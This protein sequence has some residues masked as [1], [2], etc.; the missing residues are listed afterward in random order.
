MTTVV[1]LIA[2]SCALVGYVLAMGLA[3]AAG[4]P[5]PPLFPP[6]A[7]CVFCACTGAEHEAVWDGDEFLGTRCEAH[8]GH[9]FAI[10]APA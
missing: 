7:V 2:L 4:K 10:E 1:A 3:R 9:K 8:G 5:T 6:D